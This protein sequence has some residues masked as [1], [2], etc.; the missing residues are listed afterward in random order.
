MTVPENEPVLT[1][2]A[3]ETLE[4]VGAVPGAMVT[5]N[6]RELLVPPAVLTVT[7]CE[8]KVALVLMAT[9][10]VTCVEVD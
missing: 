8:P 1:G 10:Q 9:L 7:E 5:V 3:M 4:I 2:E 6:V